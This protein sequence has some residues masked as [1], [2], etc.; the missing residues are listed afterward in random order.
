MDEVDG[1][2]HG[3]NVQVRGFGN[4][5]LPKSLM[6][7]VVIKLVRTDGV[8]LVQASYPVTTGM[9]KRLKSQAAPCSSESGVFEDDREV[10][11]SL[12]YDM[13]SEWCEVESPLSISPRSLR[14]ER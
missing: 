6:R 14:P 11:I 4:Q 9:W 8:G 7:L 3:K 10:R 1:S 12:N 2:D 13:G 5:W